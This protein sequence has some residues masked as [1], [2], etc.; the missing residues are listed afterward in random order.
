MMKKFTILALLLF[1]IYSS[2][3][4]PKIEYEEAT[5][6]YPNAEEALQE[7]IDWGYFI[8]PEEWDNSDSKKIKLAVAFL[9]NRSDSKDTNPVIM[10][11]GGPGAGSIEGIGWWL[12]HPIREK[13]DIILVDARGT[14]LSSPRL[15]PDLGSEF[16]KILAKNQSPKQDEE[17]KVLAAL[18]CKQQLIG[19]GINVDAYNSENIAN[20]LH[21]IKEYYKYQS[22]NVY[23]VSYGTYVA[24]VYANKYPDD[25]KTL[26]I[27]S[28]ISEISQYYTY[29]TSNYVS[30][31][32]KVFKNCK[33]DPNC[34]AEY[35]NLEDVYYGVIDDLTKSPITVKVDKSTIEAGTFTYN[36]EDYKIAIHQALY[37]KRLIEVLPLLIYQFHNKNEDALSSLVAAFSGALGLDYGMYFCV[38]CNETLPEN[39]IDEYNADAR[40]HQRL[41]GGLSFYNSDFA[42]CNKWNNQAN[43]DLVIS[44]EL[45]DDQIEDPLTSAINIP[46]LIFVGN[47]DPITPHVNGDSLNNQITNSTLLKAGSYGHASSFTW[48]GFEMTNKFINDP[49]TKISNEEFNTKPNISFV[50]D[51]YINGGISNLGNSV[52]AMEILFFAPLIIAVL[53]CIIAVFIYL[54]SLFRRRKGSKLANKIIKILLIIS[55]IV[56]ISALVGFVLAIKETAENNF[57]ILAFGIPED[58]SYLFSLLPVFFVLLLLALVYFVISIKKIEDRSIVFGVLFSN[59]LLGVYF[60]YWGLFSFL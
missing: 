27:D 38:S 14:G 5:S 21:A 12:N 22:W 1:S 48:K 24:Q 25:V 10:I 35:P 42:V 23:G 8:I 50:Q 18:S 33:D 31:L 34:N 58:K 26:I 6:F 19:K 55:S 60:L 30:S 57:Y 28:P 3:Q 11:D 56:G 7:G 40:K 9:K 49:N 17:D 53:I 47:Y 2:A 39:Q 16:L 15:C 20:D 37:Q 29:N 36:A 52:N 13:S 41:K 4:L 54:V 46:T 51:I 44:D 32:N 45:G 43:D 59:I